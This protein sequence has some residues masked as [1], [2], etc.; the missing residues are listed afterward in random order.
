MMDALIISLW[1]M[2]KLLALI[3][4]TGLLL[5]ALIGLFT[6]YHLLR[7]SRSPA[8]ES[9][10]INRIRLWW[11]ALTREDKF[12]GLFPWLKRDEWDNVN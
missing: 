12:V 9:N 11:F 6:V 3:A 7:T 1:L 4:N 5:F 10:R 8:D 2:L